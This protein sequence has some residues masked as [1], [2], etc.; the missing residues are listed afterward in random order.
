[1]KRGVPDVVKGERKRE[2]NC[3]ET[4]NAMY[5]KRYPCEHCNKCKEGLVFSSE[6]SHYYFKA[7]IGNRYERCN[8]KILF[9]GKE[10]INDRGDLSKTEIKE[11]SSILDVSNPHYCGTVYTAALVLVKEPKGATREALKEFDGIQHEF[12]LTNYYKCAFKNDS[13]NHGVKHSAAMTENCCKILLDEIETLRPH[14]VII[15][16]KFADGALWRALKSVKG[17]KPE[18][19]FRSQSAN[20]QATKHYHNDGSAFFVV[21]GYHPCAHGKRWNKTLGELT[22]ALSHVI[23]CLNRN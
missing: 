4:A 7:K 12:C 14:I 10:S 8:T 22:K 5:E 17:E 20:I 3:L 21:W 13:K 9:V 2:M 15:Q 1:M 19:V 16:G 18:T 11:P 23:N 6:H